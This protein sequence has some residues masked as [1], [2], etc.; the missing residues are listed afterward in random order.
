MKET[1]YTIPVNDAFNEGGECPFCNMKKNLEKDSLDYVLGAS[2]ME[3][4]I[5]EETN[6]MGFCKKH[7]KDMYKMGNRLGLALIIQT[8]LQKIKN[9][10]EKLSPSLKEDKKG[11]F[12]K[13][14]SENKVVSYIKNVSE[15]CYVCN[16]INENF[17][18]YLDTFFYM[19][20]KDKDI[21]EKV[22]NS[23]GFCIEHFG[24]LIGM[25]KEKLSQKE[26][27]EFIDIIVPI[28]IKN[29][30]RLLGEVDHFINK[31]DHNYKDAPW[32]TAK[33]SLIRAIL[34]TS[35]EFVEE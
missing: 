32:G 12:S 10:I 25:A 8:H 4:D 33:D 22:K 5:R 27:E 29:L 20:K 16:R 35:S 11:F 28:E 2:Y 15:S 21:K 23:K 3:D 19:W 24:I 17:E 6:K 14:K 18:R 34:K 9:D 26:Y 30:D 13:S 31:F 1:I 7:Y